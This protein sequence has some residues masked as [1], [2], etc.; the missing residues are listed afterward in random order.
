MSRF[1]LWPRQRRLFCLACALASLLSL[2]VPGCADETTDATTS[3]DALSLE[4]LAISGLSPLLEGSILRVEARGLDPTQSAT[5]KLELTS[6]D[7]AVIVLDVQPPTTPDPTPDPTSDPTQ[8]NALPA[9]ALTRPAIAALSKNAPSISA[10]FTAILYE[11]ARAS[12]PLPIDLTLSTLLSVTL[13]EPLDRDGFR[14]DLVVLRGDGFLAPG[15]GT[16]EAELSGQFQPETGDPFPLTAR[17]PVTLADPTNRSRGLLR[18]TTD[19]G[20]P[21][22]GTFLGTITLHTTL[23]SGNSSQS[24]TLSARL[25]FGP[26]ALLSHS[27]AAPHLG[28]F[29]TFYGGGFLGDTSRNGEATLLRFEGVLELPDGSQQPFGPQE[30]STRWTNGQQVQMG[31]DVTKTPSGDRLISS[32]FQIPRGTFRGQVT[33]VVLAGVEDI[34]GDPLPVELP[35]PGVR[36]VVQVVFLP[37]FYS[38][39]SRFGLSIASEQITAKTFGRIQSLYTGYAVEIVSEIPPDILPSAV[40]IVEIGGADP[41]GLGMFGYDN[42]P[43]KDIGNVRLFDRIGGA[44]ATSQADGFPGYGGVFIDSILYWSSH[45]DFSG[46]RPNGTPDPDPLF[47]EIFDPVRNQPATLDE[48]RG[49]GDPTRVAQV[50]RAVDALGSIIGETTAHELGHSLGLSQPTG[51]S[52]AFHSIAPGDGCLMDSGAFRPLGER[53]AQPGFPISHFCDDEPAY[54][55]EILGQ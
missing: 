32:F 21:I 17:L 54:L 49:Q 37:G 55:Q 27:P 23:R 25:G 44:N 2:A 51:P 39:L 40:T 3:P 1:P 10:T 50:A 19:L 52:D 43:G 29:V 34:Q 8:Q 47:D 4:L 13:S 22:A 9:F 36:Q 18:L 33:P 53:A 5:L 12:A 45:P 26:P 35:L 16:A 41:N 48:V 20:G 42:T 7:G 6:P 30:A 31:L 28:Q 24:D 38:S 46:E 15:E 14:E 11:G